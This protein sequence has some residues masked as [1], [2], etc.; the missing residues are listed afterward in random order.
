MYKIHAHKLIDAGT[1]PAQNHQM[2]QVEKVELE[3][4][5]MI[6]ISVHNPLNE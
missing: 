6:P 1:L 5:P 4:T 3:G 2:N